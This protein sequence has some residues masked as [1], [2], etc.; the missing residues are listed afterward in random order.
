MRFKLWLESEDKKRLKIYDTSKLTSDDQWRFG[1][2]AV[3]EDGYLVGYHVTD[4]TDKAM[5]ILRSSKQVTATYRKGV[6]KY[7]ELGPGF[8]VSASPQVWMGRSR[9]KWDF[10]ETLS[11]EQM[12]RLADA[13]RQDQVLT[14]TKLPDG[15]VFQHVS[16]N[17]RENG[18]RYIDEWLK[19]KHHPILVFLAGQPYN[20]KFWEPQFLRKLGIEPSPTPK[21]LKVKFSGKFV[22]LET[23]Y[24]WHNVS[25]SIRAGLDGGFTKG[26][27]ST[28]PELCI[29][30]KQCIQSIELEN[31]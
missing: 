20:I 23:S 8:Y 10:L 13:I 6:G 5:E 7:A 18:L 28:N 1:N 11:D 15:R 16:A 21:M 25:N 12:H 14:G 17:E 27:F 29:W 30:R 26:G 4:N 9:G 31:G 2:A 22:D 24:D 3:V 19:S